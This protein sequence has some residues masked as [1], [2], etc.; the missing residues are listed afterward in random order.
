MYGTAQ[1]TAASSLLFFK[2]PLLY[3]EQELLPSKTVQQGRGEKIDSGYKM[4]TAKQ[5]SGRR[6]E[7]SCSTIKRENGFNSCEGRRRLE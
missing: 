6:K 3:I 2:P 1:I 4:R 5:S 7:T